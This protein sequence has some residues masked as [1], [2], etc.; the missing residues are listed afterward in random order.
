MERFREIAFTPA[1]LDAQQ[2][3]YGRIQ[4][5]PESRERDR[6]GPDEREFLEARDSFYLA[7][8][9]S[10]GWPYL[11]HRGGPPG[12]LRVLD[13]RRLAFPD[14][15]GNRQLLTVGNLAGNDRVA[16]LAMDYPGRQR[17]KVLGRARAGSAAQLGIYTGTLD[18]PKDVE[19]WLEIRVEGLDW[20]C[21]K[22]I[23]PRYT[24]AEVEAHTAELRA[25][26]RALE[27]ILHEGDS[28]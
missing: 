22:H 4:A 20:N 6:I 15:R 8:V 7:T 23:T 19:R 10:E 25:R 3:A 28:G 5:R 9:N 1:V 27:A 18:E 26:I 12:F 21:P 2:A 17:L 13:E 11:Q 14:R 16:L 24:L